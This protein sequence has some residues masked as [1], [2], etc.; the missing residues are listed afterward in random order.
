MQT[1]NA[2][3]LKVNG[4]IYTGWLS[5]EITSKLQTLA[6]RFS[7]SATRTLAKNADKTDGIN[8]GDSVEVFIGEDKVLTGYVM[9]K[10]ASYTATGIN[11]SISGA[12]KPI[13]LEQC[14][15]P[16]GYPTSFKNQTHLVNLQSVCKPYGINVIDEVG[17][18]KKCDFEIK[19]TEK[20]WNAIVAYLQKNC[21]LIGDDKNGNVVIRSTSSGGASADVLE[22][23]T[24]I[25]EGS[26]EQD[27]SGLFSQYVVLGQAANPLSE[28]PLSSNQLKSVET[29]LEVKR[30]RPCVI[31]QKGNVSLTDLKKK[32]ISQ[33]DTSIGNADK[34]AYKVR[35]WRQSNGELWKI[36]KTVRINDSFFGGKRTLL[37]SSVKYELGA[38]GFVTTLECSQKKAF[39]IYEISDDT[40]AKVANFDDVKEGSGKVGE[41]EWV[42]K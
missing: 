4:K 3:S 33:R 17:N 14:C 10:V 8:A 21:L 23:G 37:I 27:H 41:S 1:E 11:I 13:D 24:N 20:I 25:L 6:R 19:P 12:S 32:A 35:G 2:V 22:T 29:N 36:N 18:K 7:V 9:R 26:R 5:V 15:L 34:V 31:E 39:D 28:L 38:K 16:D 40:K 42:R 30:I